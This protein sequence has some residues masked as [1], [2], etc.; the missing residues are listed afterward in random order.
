MTISKTRKRK[1]EDIANAVAET[2]VP[3]TASKAKKSRAEKTANVTETPLPAT[4]VRKASKKV[5][6]QL[7][8]T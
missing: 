3:V 5:L 4:R 2:P 8:G 6:E 7:K 1:A